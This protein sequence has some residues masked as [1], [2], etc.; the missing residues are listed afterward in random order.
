MCDIQQPG[1]KLIS[2]KERRRTKSYT[3]QKIMSIGIECKG[4]PWTPLAQSPGASPSPEHDTT[5]YWNND[6]LGC[7]KDVFTAFST[8]TVG[9]VLYYSQIEAMSQVQKWIFYKSQKEGGRLESVKYLQEKGR[10]DLKKYRFGKSPYLRIFYN[11][12]TY[13][14]SDVKRVS[15][16]LAPPPPTHSHPHK[17]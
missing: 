2:P 1:T 9:S 3:S 13:L 17:P 14:T 7:R 8:K 10:A 11:L 12:W 5:E 4:K 15:T 16:T 6:D